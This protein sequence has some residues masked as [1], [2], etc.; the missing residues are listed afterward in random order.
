[1]QKENVKFE[2]VQVSEFTKAK[3]LNKMMYYFWLYSQAEQCY[4]QLNNV[5]FQLKM[6]KNT[7]K[8]CEI[9]KCAYI[10]IW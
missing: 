2:N 9:Q 5:I 7:T 8:K 3:I 1:M 6:C 4:R 10:R